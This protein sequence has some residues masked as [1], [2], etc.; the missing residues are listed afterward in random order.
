[1]RNQPGNDPD[2]QPTDIMTGQ[3]RHGMA[4][5]GTILIS[6]PALKVIACRRCHQ[7]GHQRK[8]HAQNHYISKDALHS[9]S[10]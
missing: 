7:W 6:G 3:E 4:N 8:Q 5:T 1:M 9:Q 2:R 10:P